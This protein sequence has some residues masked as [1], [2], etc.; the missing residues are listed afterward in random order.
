MYEYKL[1]IILLKAHIQF[2]KFIEELKTNILELKATA[3]HLKMLA[4]FHT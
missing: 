4:G 3:E 2:N 1:L